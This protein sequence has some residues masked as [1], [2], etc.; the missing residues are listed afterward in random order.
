MADYKV[1]LSANVKYGKDR[2]VKGDVLEVTKAEYDHFLKSKLIQDDYTEPIMKTPKTVDEMTLAELKA[3]ATEH[4]IDLGEAKKK[5]EILGAIEKADAEKLAGG[6][7]DGEG[8]G[9]QTPSDE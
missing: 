5:D 1:K 2:F 9:G 8:E 4:E 6:K 3:Y 7:D